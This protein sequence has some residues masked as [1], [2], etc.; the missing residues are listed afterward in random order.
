[1]EYIIVSFPTNRF[2]YIDGEKGGIT[3]DVLRIEAGTHEFDLGNRR[4]YQPESQEV[5]VEGTTVLQPLKI[6]F[7]R[8]D[9]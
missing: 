5:E 3:N 1:M 6:V 2:V 4:N 9:K 7:T 8:K